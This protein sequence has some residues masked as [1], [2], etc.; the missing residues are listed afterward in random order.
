MTLYNQIRRRSHDDI[1]FSKFNC[2][3]NF[4]PNDILH[5]V[6]A[7]PGNHGT[8]SPCRMNFVCD[9]IADSLMEQ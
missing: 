2:N 9:G 3:L 4:F 7:H 8:Y 1:A 5:D 6:V